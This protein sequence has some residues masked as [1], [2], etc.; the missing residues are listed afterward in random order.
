[1][2]APSAEPAGPP[3]SSPAVGARTNAR[4][5]AVQALYEIDLTNAPAA[6]PVLHEFLARRW[7]GADVSDEPP[8]ADGTDETKLDSGLFSTIVSGATGARAE[9][10]GL[11]D[12][13]LSAGWTVQRLEVLVRCVLRAGTYELLHAPETPA[14]VIINEY[15]D[16]A[17][18][19]FS[20]SEPGLVN[21]VLD[22]IA[23]TVRPNE[24]P[25]GT[26]GDAR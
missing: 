14:A 15:M 10:D 21:G 19:F 16:L 1:M 4:L 17:H 24:A 12:W 26:S 18:A 6:D 22:R 2:S 9:I 23:R 5:A 11:I 3:A 7:A 13:S 20:G 25:P 8:S